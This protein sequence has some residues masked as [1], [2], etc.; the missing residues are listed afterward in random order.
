[1]V[2]FHC[3]VS[4]LECNLRVFQHTPGTYPRETHKAIVYFQAFLNLL[5]VKGDA[6]CSKGRVGWG[7]LRIEVLH[8]ARVGRDIL[9]S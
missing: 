9:T 6:R 2:V 3:H 4:L 5:G 8:E 7:S 1:M